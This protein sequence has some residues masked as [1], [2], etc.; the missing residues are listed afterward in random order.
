VKNSDEAV[1]KVLAGLRECDAPVGME[2]RIVDALEHH[3]AARARSGWRQLR[4]GWLGSAPP[5]VAIRSVAWGVAVAGVV[6]VAIVIPAMRR[7]GRGSAQFPTRSIAQSPARSVA[8]SPA[9]SQMSSVVAGSLHRATQQT[10]AES[11]P[12][13]RQSVRPMEKTD[14]RSA[15]DVHDGESV[16]VEEM[17]AASHPAPPMPLTEQERLLLRIAHRGDP[18]EL[19][20]LDPLRRAARD[21]EEQ[22]EFQRF[23]KPRTIDQPTIEQPAAG[24]PTTSQPTTEQP[25]TAQPTTET[26]TPGDNE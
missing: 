13:L 1:E 3:A 6:A 4:P 2:R 25:T 23:F 26:A 18:V 24:Q 20:M 8:Q 22:T 19:A 7:L 11:T 21:V 17:L 14:V 10:V 9:Q 12:L 5:P 15:G 16:A